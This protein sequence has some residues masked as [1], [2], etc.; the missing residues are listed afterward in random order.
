MSVDALLK[1]L[2]RPV[3]ASV[4]WVPAG[5]QEQGTGEPHTEQVGSPRSP[6]SPE[7]R[8]YANTMAD[9]PSSQEPLPPLNRRR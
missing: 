7:R 9:A 2:A 3:H 5:P 1:R 8:D 6:S 4:P